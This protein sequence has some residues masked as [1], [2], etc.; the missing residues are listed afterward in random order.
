MNK[1]LSNTRSDSFVLTAGEVSAI[2]KEDEEEE[3]GGRSPSL[4]G[5]RVLGIV[6]LEDVLEHILNEDILDE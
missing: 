3:E 6:T 1:V 2:N 4:Q 5:A